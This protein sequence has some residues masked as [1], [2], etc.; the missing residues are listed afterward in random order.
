MKRI[1][2]ITPLPPKRQKELKRWYLLTISVATLLFFSIIIITAIQGYQYWAL[3]KKQ[4]QLSFELSNY[5]SVINQQ[6]HDHDQHTRLKKK[7]DRLNQYKSNP[8]NPAAILSIIKTAFNGMKLKSLSINAQQFEIQLSANSPDQITAC[9]KY[10]HEYR[11]QSKPLFSRI[12]LVSLSHNQQ[13]VDATITGII[14]NKLKER[15]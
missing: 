5:T 4:R 13:Q 1:N 12:K 2:F 11:Q 8:K 15:M 10:L 7:I 3:H 14:L 6:K 9:I